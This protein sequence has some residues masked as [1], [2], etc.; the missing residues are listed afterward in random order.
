M[1][2]SL[3]LAALM[4][5]IALSDGKTLVVDPT[6][7]GHPA[8]L[9]RAVD[10]AS[11]GDEII[12]MSGS[13]LGAVIDRRLTIIG[14]GK[15]IINGQGSSAL[16][17]SAPGCRLSNLSIE[18]SGNSPGVM[19]QSSDNVVDSCLVSGSSV[20]LEILGTNNTVRYSQID[21]VMGINLAGSRCKVLGAAFSGDK[22]IQMKASSENIIQ[23]CRFLT[24]T[25]IEL[26]SSTRNK[27]E[28]NNFSGINFGITLTRSDQNWLARNQISGSFL[29]GLDLLESSGNNLSENRMEGCKLGISIRQSEKNRLM[30]N[31]CK[32]NE[33]AGIYL[34]GSG[35]NRLISNYLSGNGN[36][37]LLS[38]SSKNQIISCR[39]IGNIYGISLR[40]SGQNI[41]KN[42]SLM[43]N[44]CN[45]R[46]DSGSQLAPTPDGFIQD[47]DFSNT[48]E[49]K[50]ICY[51]VGAHGSNISEDCGF[52]GL[53]GC[54]NIQ[55][56]NQSISNSSAG[57]LLV[58]SSGCKVYNCTIKL[59]EAGIS[60]INSK[61]CTA[62]MCKAENCKS[63]LQV[64]KSY[65]GTFS[66]DATVN[67]S[68]SGFRIDD[69]GNLTMKGC[70]A[71]GNM[72]GLLIKNS[73][74]C[75]LLKIK[76]TSN[77]EAGVELIGSS[78]CLLQAVEASLNKK[79]ISLSGSNG[80][81]IYDNKAR[82]NI[83]DGIALVQLSNSKVERN[84]ASEN[85]QGLY[86]QSSKGIQISDN[87]LSANSRHGLRMSISSGCNVTDNRFIRNK[88][89]GANL[90][91]CR[92]NYIYHN[93]FIN[94]GLQNAVDNG[95]NQWDAGLNAGGNYW[96]DHQVKGN[97]GNIP[98]QIQTKGVDRY[99]FQEPGG[100]GQNG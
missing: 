57:V 72:Q 11:P 54:Q 77:E 1:N 20:G 87:N 24:A 71:I 28:K 64:L 91:D 3:L 50:P 13:Y 47:I 52:V 36:A 65:G 86:V 25:G 32:K 8:T 19:L 60:L 5:L 9:A 94:N 49:G 76:A 63:G 42:N 33:R 75:Q 95:E 85:G 31:S 7:K 90:I 89:S 98:R 40:D 23:S 26:V 92:G 78:D 97:P 79:G 35:D 53:I 59:C 16:I 55:I 82:M 69:S 29:S 41:L 4:L 74:L 37:I 66:A 70:T 84:I 34:N 38:S 58:G 2:R 27:I 21:S 15:V 68:E 61:D 81:K 46:I 80:C 6:V 43:A 96:S 17:I 51:L 18:G 100:W 22:G 44:I 30:N 56:L 83:Q 39:A 62:E 48:A 45:L 88:I 73:K 10:L 99:P 93:I 67:C 12:V 14:S